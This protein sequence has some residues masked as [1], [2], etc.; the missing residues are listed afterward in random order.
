MIKWTAETEWCITDA[1]S[2]FRR[3]FGIFQFLRHLD[4]FLRMCAHM[5]GQGGR[6][7]KSVNW[8]AWSGL[9]T[10]NDSNF[11]DPTD[12]AREGVLPVGVNPQS[13]CTFWVQKNDGNSH[14]GGRQHRKAI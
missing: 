7:K 3:F 13:F 4:F 6:W 1:T 8:D 10:K 5:H 2:N 9:W 14:F 12:V 11:R